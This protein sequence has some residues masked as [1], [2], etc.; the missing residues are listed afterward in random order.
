M[1]M[2][3]NDC[4]VREEEAAEEKEAEEGEE[5]AEE[6]VRD[7]FVVCTSIVITDE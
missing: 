4:I 6:I 7:S 3:C 5:T 2:D 1:Y